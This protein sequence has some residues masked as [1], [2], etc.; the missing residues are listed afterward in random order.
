MISKEDAVKFGDAIIQAE[1][2]RRGPAG[3][4]DGDV[5]LRCPYCHQRALGMREKLSLG[6]MRSRA[7]RSCGGLVSVS[8]WSLLGLLPCYF[9]AFLVRRLKNNFN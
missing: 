5:A 3:R 4:R 2:V 1:R 9:S 7:C 8:W 6:P